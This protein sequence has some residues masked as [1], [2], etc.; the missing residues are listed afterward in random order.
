VA[1]RGDAYTNFF[2]R[3]AKGRQRKNYIPCVRTAEG[4]YIWSHEEKEQMLFN[5]FWGLIG[6]AEQRQTT[7]EW[8]QLHMPCIMS[9]HQID[10]PFSEEE[11]QRAISELPAEKAPGA[12]GFTGVFYRAYWEIIKQEIIASFHCFYNLTEGPLPKLNGALL[13]LLPKKEVSEQPE[14]YRSISLIHS[15]V[16]LVSKVLPIRFTR[17]ID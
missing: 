17:H 10:G 12:D 5:Y 7:F 14:D 8:D 3:K 9:Q 2:H 11:I 4:D 15:F 13:T 16:K 1:Q 6:C